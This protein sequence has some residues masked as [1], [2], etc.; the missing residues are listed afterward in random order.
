MKRKQRTYEYGAYFRCQ[1]LYKK[2]LTLLQEL[3]L[4]RIGNEDGMYFQTKER[5]YYN[6]EQ[7]LQQQ[8][9][10]TLCEEAKM[11]RKRNEM[12]L[13]MINKTLTGFP[14]RKTKTE[15]I[16]VKYSCDSSNKKKRRCMLMM[17]DTT[18]KCKYVKKGSDVTKDNE[19]DSSFPRRCLTFNTTTT[20]MNNYNRGWSCKRK[21]YKEYEVN[22]GRKNLSNVFDTVGRSDKGMVSLNNT[23][24]MKRTMLL[25]KTSV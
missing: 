11:K 25:K 3:P 22:K 2:L 19:D 12:M 17:M 14:I 9:L 4:E 16:K 23:K 1:D 20:T 10:V 7:Q 24:I 15:V 6:K 8:R 18:A 13:P 21:K 5:S